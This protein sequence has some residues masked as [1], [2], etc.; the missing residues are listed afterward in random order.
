MS[1]RVTQSLPSSLWYTYTYQCLTYKA[2]YGYRHAWGHHMKMMAERDTSEPETPE[3]TKQTTGCQVRV[4]I[5]KLTH[6]HQEES[7]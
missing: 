7:T 2:K 1:R 6:S 3:F 4:R 5:M